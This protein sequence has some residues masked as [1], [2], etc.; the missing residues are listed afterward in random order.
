VFED[1]KDKEEEKGF[2]C[3][4]KYHSVPFSEDVQGRKLVVS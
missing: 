3:A 4:P 1:Y 2:S